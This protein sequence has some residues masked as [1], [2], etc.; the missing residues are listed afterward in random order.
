M[1]QATD[2]QVQNM[3][4]AI[5]EIRAGGDAAFARAWL[6][7]A[8]VHLSTLEVPGPHTAS[9]EK[10]LPL[11]YCLEKATGSPKEVIQG[12]LH[13]SLPRLIFQA[14]LAGRDL[15]VEDGY[16]ALEMIRSGLGKGN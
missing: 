9:T 7:W 15:R 14:K 5:A 1:F 3:Q 8:E 6:V 11:V 4:Q 10:I 2:Q 16:A 13:D 12:M